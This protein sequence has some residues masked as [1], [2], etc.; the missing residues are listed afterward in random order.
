MGKNLELSISIF[1]VR[2]S[3]ANSVDLD[4]TSYCSFKA[5]RSES[6][7]LVF[8]FITIINHISAQCT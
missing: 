7:V 5:V 2:V 8:C 6:A 1:L 3:S 4:Q